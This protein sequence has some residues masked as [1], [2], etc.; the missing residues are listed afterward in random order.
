MPSRSANRRRASLGSLYREIHSRYG[1]H[2]PELVPR[3][4]VPEV[5]ES[6]IML[7][8]QALGRD[9]QRLSGLPYHLPPRQSTER[10]VLSR[11]D[12]E[13]DRFL[14]RFGYTIQ[15]DGEGQ[16]AYHTDLVHFFPGRRPRGTGDL[17]PAEADINWRWFEREVNLLQP[18][19]VVTLGL[20]P[21]RRCFE[22]YAGR[23][24]QRLGDVAGTPVSCQIRGQHLE[25]IAVHHPSGAF[26]HPTS[27]KV[28]QR[29]ARYIR[30]LLAG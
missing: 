9:T 15:V 16:Y 24:V 27:S 4:V 5:L 19:V 1:G 25:L 2:D 3:R 14:A 8:G 29:A 20:E 17:V 12:K 30:Q 18:I 22:R 6:R 13:L 11:G 26:Q 10:P 7:V 23:S 21:S 28:Y